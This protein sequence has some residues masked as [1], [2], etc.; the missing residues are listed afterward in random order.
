L[1]LIEIEK[2][3]YYIKI[4]KNIIKEFDKIGGYTL[5]EHLLLIGILILALYKLEI[6]FMHV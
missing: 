6:D 4:Y 5:K 2:Y 1:K 3:V